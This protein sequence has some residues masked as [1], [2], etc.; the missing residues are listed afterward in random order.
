MSCG[1]PDKENDAQIIAEYNR[2]KE[3][4][5]VSD[6]YYVTYTMENNICDFISDFDETEIQSIIREEHGWVVNV[7]KPQA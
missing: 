3:E 2:R 5:P 4:I 7:K 6:F 1:C